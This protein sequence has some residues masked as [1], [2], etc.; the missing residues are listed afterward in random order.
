MRKRVSLLSLTVV[1]L[2]VCAYVSP[3]AQ[4]PDQT[5]SGA[6]SAIVIFPVGEKPNPNVAAMPPV[7]FNHALHEKW[8]KKKD[9][10]CVVCHHT[11]DPVACTSCH[12]VEGTADSEHINLD[13]AVHSLWITSQAKNK[14]VSCVSCHEKQLKHRE[15]AGCHTRLVGNARDKES[16]CKVCHTISPK[17]G[18]EQMM[19]GIANNLPEKENEQIA[20]ATVKARTPIEYWS[21]MKAPYKVKIDALADQYEPVT[22]NHRHHVISL[23][24]RI[25]KKR[26]AGAFHTSPATLCVT[27]HHHS[28]ASA[29]PP[30]CSS[31]HSQQIN[32]EQPDRPKLMAAYHLQCMSCHTD[33]KVARPRNTDC[34]TCHML[35]PAT[36]AAKN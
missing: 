31:C 35:K 33:M 27:C 23:L 36:S 6:P 4:E 11:G 19:E 29:T 34:E 16:W 8:L 10:E 15:C 14:P 20:S 5:D 24:E 17:L 22:F 1:F 12:T 25:Q 9:G 18:D 3:Q 30:K 13:R 7:A 21:P 28:P 2:V 32:V 26:L